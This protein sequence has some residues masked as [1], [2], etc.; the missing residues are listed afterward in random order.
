MHGGGAPQVKQAAQRRIQELVLPSLGLLAEY[1][2]RT[3]PDEGAPAQARIQA[4]RD[5][6]DRAGFSAT[7]RLDLSADLSVKSPIDVELD[8]L[9]D[10]IRDRAQSPSD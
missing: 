10:R 3:D 6:L 8:E 9:A 5:I 4:A 1:I 2:E 7:H